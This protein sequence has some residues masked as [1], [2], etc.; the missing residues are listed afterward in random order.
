[1]AINA[2][3]YLVDIV[4]EL[5]VTSAGGTMVVDSDVLAGKID[6]S[7]FGIKVSL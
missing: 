3:C 5:S 1:M 4:A 7:F 2:S 6:F